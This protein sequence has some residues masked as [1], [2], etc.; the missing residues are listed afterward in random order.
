MLQWFLIPSVSAFALSDAVK[1]DIA[2]GQLIEALENGNDA[3]VMNATGK[4]R[5][6]K[7]EDPRLN[8]FDGQALFNTKQYHKSQKSLESYVNTTGRKAEFY[9]DAITLLGKLELVVASV[10]EQ[11][12]VNTTNKKTH[13]QTDLIKRSITDTG[14]E[15]LV[16]EHLTEEAFKKLNNGDS[17]IQ[18][19]SDFECGKKA[20]LITV[21]KDGE[22][23]IECFDLFN[24][25]EKK[26]DDHL[27]TIK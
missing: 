7:V 26:I 5:E 27:Q 20:T 8:F 1:I 15:A 24:K 10:T 4:L 17:E 19:D 23:H 21:D 3:D 9:Q 14:D 11:S 12:E 25:E 22:Q 16:I 6:L 18:I 2:T 13:R